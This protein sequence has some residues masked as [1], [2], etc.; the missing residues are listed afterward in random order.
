MLVY[1]IVQT[2]PRYVFQVSREK[3]L[4]IKLLKAVFARTKTASVDLINYLVLLYFM[5]YGKCHI[6]SS[7]V[8][9]AIF[10]TFQ[11]S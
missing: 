3:Q 9:S 10:Y 8:D 5:T 11:K 2:F 7:A 4:N 6:L 1:R